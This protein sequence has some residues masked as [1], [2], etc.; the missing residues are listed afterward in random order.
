MEGKCEGGV[1]TK[2]QIQLP[3]RV[4]VRDHSETKDGSLWVVWL[5][6][7]R[8]DG[9]DWKLMKVGPPTNCK[10]TAEIQAEAFRSL[11]STPAGESQVIEYVKQS[12]I[13]DGN[14]EELTRVPSTIFTAPSG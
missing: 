10:R 4:E 14:G 7:V 2:E 8:P 3:L 9:K 12:W 1:G 5:D 6:S 11:L 13:T